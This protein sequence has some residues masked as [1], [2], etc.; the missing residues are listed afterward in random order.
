[1]YPSLLSIK[2]KFLKE[3]RQKGTGMK[4]QPKTCGIGNIV[5]SDGARATARKLFL[6]RQNVEKKDPAVRQVRK[7]MD[8]RRKECKFGCEIK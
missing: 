3:S 1:M 6:C 5:A 8:E 7:W 2:K 4:R